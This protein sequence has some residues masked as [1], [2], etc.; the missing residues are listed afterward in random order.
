MICYPG[1][2]Q[3]WQESVRWSTGDR[4]TDIPD[5]HFLTP[6]FCP[7]HPSCLCTAT[8]TPGT[9]HMHAHTSGWQ[10][11][12]LASH[13][14]MFFST[15]LILIC[16]LFLPFSPSHPLPFMFSVFRQMLPSVS[17]FLYPLALEARKTSNGTFGQP[18]SSWQLLK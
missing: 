14:L 18:P 3:L 6:P 1:K 4:K 9:T 16:F 12:N 7:P 2:Q 15:P 17:L 13:K 11:P 8:T 5:T 10:R